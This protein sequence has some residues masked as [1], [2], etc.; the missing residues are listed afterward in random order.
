[1]G[2]ENLMV[3]LYRVPEIKAVVDT[4]TDWVTLFGFLLTAIAV[5]A[6]SIYNSSTFQRTISSQEKLA[7][8]NALAL[9]Y[10]SKTEAL[11]KSR[12]EWINT[13]REEVAGI[14]SVGNDVYTLSQ[15][16]VDTSWVQGATVEEFRKN[17]DIY[18]AKYAEFSSKLS[19]AR[20]H[21][22]KIE[23][24]VNP[25]EVESK[26][27]LAALNDYVQAAASYS[28]II[29]IGGVVVAKAQT[30]LKNEWIKVKHME[31]A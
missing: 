5:V 21:F 26:E 30:I 23:L 19:R 11:A 14:L 22:A 9:R 10:Q 2:I 3:T 20:F 6:G 31:D 29:D 4:G 15:A 7:E 27:L 12:Q 17:Q 13:L 16:I 28:K 1:M 24:L 25:N 18:E 8:R